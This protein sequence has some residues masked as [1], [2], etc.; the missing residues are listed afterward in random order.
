[1][2][3][4]NHGQFEVLALDRKTR[5]PL[6]LEENCLKSLDAGNIGKMRIPDLGS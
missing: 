6:K 3:E 2:A 1:M 5:H 4:T